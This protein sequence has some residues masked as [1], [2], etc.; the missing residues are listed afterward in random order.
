MTVE[1]AI[2]EVGCYN[3]IVLNCGETGG[4][5]MLWLSTDGIGNW[6]V[7]FNDFDII[8]SEEYDYERSFSEQVSEKL[9]ELGSFVDTIDLSTGA[10]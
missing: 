9:S 10:K 3:E 8:N 1:K 2:Y 5:F 6:D 7:K 4:R